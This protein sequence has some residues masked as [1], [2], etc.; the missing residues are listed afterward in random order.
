MNK[1]SQGFNTPLL[2]CMHHQLQY[3]NFCILPSASCVW[4]P[5]KAVISRDSIKTMIDVL[6][7]LYPFFEVKLKQAY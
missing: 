5:L 1:S 6:E 7:R 4:F 2:Y 3:E